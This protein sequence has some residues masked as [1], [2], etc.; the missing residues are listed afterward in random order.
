MPRWESGASI[1]NVPCYWF[2][3]RAWAAHSWHAQSAMKNVLGGKKK[4]F[5]ILPEI[6]NIDVDIFPLT[7]KL[8]GAVMK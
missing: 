2:K 4:L 5:N 7:I 8:Q 3:A 6:H 1:L